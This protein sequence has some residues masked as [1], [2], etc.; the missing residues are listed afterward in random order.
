MYQNQSKPVVYQRGGWGFGAFK[1]H[2]PLKF[3]RPFKIVPNYPDCENLKMAEFST[4]TPQ[5]V[6]KKGSKILKLPPVRNCF[7]L[8]MTNKLVAIINNLKVPNFTIWNEI[9]CTK[10]QLPPELL[11][12]GLPPPDSRSLRPL[13]STECVETPLPPNKIPGYATDRGEYERNGRDPISGN[14]LKV[15][16]PG[17]KTWDFRM[18]NERHKP[19]YI[20]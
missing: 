13:F 7:T 2:S 10:L 16:W 17:F 6:R 3:R 12:R 18:R 19:Q 15:L 9:S 8:P 5:D 1:P 14:I 4:P 20:N 11:T